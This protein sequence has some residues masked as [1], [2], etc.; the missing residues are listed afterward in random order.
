[1]TAPSDMPG[2]LLSNEETSALLDAMRATDSEEKP[3]EPADLVSPEPRLR[4]LLGAVDAATVPVA[5]KAATVLMRQTSCATVVEAQPAE[6]SPFRVV[7]TAIVPGTAI[8]VLRT[9]DGALALLTFGPAL[10]SFLLDRQ[11]GA[12]L[13]LGADKGEEK[14]P[15][16]VRLSLLDQRVLRP[17]IEALSG[18]LAEELSGDAGALRVEKVTADPLEVPELPQMEPMMRVS[19]R[20]APAAF[21]S[22]DVVLAL[23][24]PAVA[25]LVGHDERDEEGPH[26]TPEERLSLARLLGQTTVEVSVLLG[27]AESNVAEVLSLEVDDIV[28]LDGVP[29]V[30]SELRVEGVRVLS[31]EPVVAHGNIALR[32]TPEA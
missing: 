3:V 2:P 11:M 9:V 12:P 1:M 7:S 25:A 14:P 20:C 28:R 4:G 6:I 29:G 30:P 5:R 10:V 15:V 21:P 13:M 8:V 22:D 31:G 23:S 19:L 32:I 27:E 24:P 18:A 26:A 17:A 16:R